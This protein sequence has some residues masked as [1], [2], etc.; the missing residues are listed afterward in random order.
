MLNIVSILIGIFALPFIIIGSIPF[1]GWSLW[2]V[3]ILPVIGAAVGALS[4]RSGGRNFNLVLLV[5]T[6]LRL[7]LGGGLF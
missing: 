5:A 7:M 4:S 3:I 6:A 1:L 2:L